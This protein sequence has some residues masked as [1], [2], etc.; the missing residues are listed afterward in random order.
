MAHFDMPILPKLALLFCRVTDVPFL[1]NGIKLV[2]GID[3]EEIG[4][5]LGREH[6]NR[7]GYVN[8]I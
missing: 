1:T 6:C 2:L 7:Y 5:R 8:E 4:N 3:L